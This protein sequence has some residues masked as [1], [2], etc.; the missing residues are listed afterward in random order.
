M[1]IL[2]GFFQLIKFIEGS[3]TFPSLELDVSYF[4]SHLDLFDDAEPADDLPEDDVLVVE[5]VRLLR[6]D[7]ELR[8]IRARPRVG[9]RKD[10]GLSRRSKQSVRK[11]R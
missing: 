3:F 2:S 7:E 9:H 5:P 6:R 8:A 4:S 11:S 10:P 1:S